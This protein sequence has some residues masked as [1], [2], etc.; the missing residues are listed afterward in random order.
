VLLR[1]ITDPTGIPW[2]A[3]H[4]LGSI[5]VY[6]EDTAVFDHGASVVTCW[7]VPKQGACVHSV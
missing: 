6:S 7:A 2:E 1:T 4:T 3:F 5:P